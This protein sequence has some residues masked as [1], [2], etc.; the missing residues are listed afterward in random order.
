MVDELKRAPDN[1]PSIGISLCTHKD[2]S[3]VRYSV[4]HENNQYPLPVGSI[5]DVYQL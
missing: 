5:D 1:N 4:S 3:V 2:A